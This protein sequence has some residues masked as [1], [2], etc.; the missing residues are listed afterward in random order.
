MSL[1]IAGWNEPQ[2][3][4]HLMGDGRA[5]RYADSSSKSED[6][7]KIG[8]TDFSGLYYGISGSDLGLTLFNALLYIVPAFIELEGGSQANSEWGFHNF[9]SGK[10]NNNFL[11]LMETTIESTV[12][13]SLSIIFTVMDFFSFS[14]MKFEYSDEGVVGVRRSIENPEEKGPIVT[15]LAWFPERPYIRTLAQFN[16]DSYNNSIVTNGRAEFA[17]EVIMRYSLFSNQNP[18]DWDLCSVFFNAFEKS[19]QN[20]SSVGGNIHEMRITPF[21]CEKV[22]HCGDNLNELLRNSNDIWRPVMT[23]GPVRDMV[24]SNSFDVD[25]YR[26]LAWQIS[27]DDNEGYYIGGKIGRLERAA[28]LTWQYVKKY[29][30][31]ND[32][33]M[34]MKHQ[35]MFEPQG[36]DVEFYELVGQ[37]KSAQD[38]SMQSRIVTIRSA[39]CEALC[40]EDDERT[41][42]LKE[43]IAES[44]SI[45]ELDGS[46]SNEGWLGLVYENSGH[47]E[48]A[49]GCYNNVVSTLDDMQT[50]TQGEEIAVYRSL[51]GLVRMGED[52]QENVD[53]Y[54]RQLMR[55][56]FFPEKLLKST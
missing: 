18:K 30:N 56:E 14:N 43:L 37:N 54:F 46:M 52:H 50:I 25:V 5:T 7:K 24:A 17:N 44:Q 31:C 9:F 42:R 13:D 33:G 6:F 55:R 27:V 12:A 16:L 2:N 28:D 39:I 41:T 11:E 49:R 53:N 3:T 23:M 47:V 51:K 10:I 36:A 4:L 40:Y 34:F 22:N 15:R 20:L 19:M 21:G 48:E 45:F 32:V 1:I 29:G 26:R 35:F 8:E 38:S